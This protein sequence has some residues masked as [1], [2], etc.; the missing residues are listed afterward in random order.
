MAGDTRFAGSIP[1]VYEECLV[2][3][4]FDPYAEDMVERALE[5][6]NASV[7]EIAAG[8]GAVALKLA[9]ALPDSR[10]VATDL[11]AGMI[12]V[13]RAKSLPGRIAWLTADAQDLAFHDESFDLVLCQFGAMFFA[14]RVKA[15]REV[16]R[17]LHDNGAFLFNVWDRLEANSG[18]EAI[19]EAVRSVVPEPKPDFLRRTPFG[20]FED[21]AI[22]ADLRAGGFSQVSL[23]RVAFASPPEQAA[24]LARGMCL[25]S[26]LMNELA[27]HPQDVRDRALQAAIAAAEDVAATEQLSMSALVVTAFP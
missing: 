8:T 2:P 24:S 4:L 21:V 26:P 23:E 6:P 25:G 13:G 1:Q 7:L 16:R 5:L 27:A 18:S 11:N 9:Q 15:Y 20:Y 17:V 22:E 3:V 19:H 10:I 12:E 14:D